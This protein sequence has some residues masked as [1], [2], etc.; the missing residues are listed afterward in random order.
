MKKHK[1]P[2]YTTLR[3]RKD[4]PGHNLLAAAQR[5]LRHN[6]GEAVL[7]GGIGLMETHLSNRFYITVAAVGRPPQKGITK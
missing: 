1:K 4:D 5:W 3:F 6:G 2:K 7:L